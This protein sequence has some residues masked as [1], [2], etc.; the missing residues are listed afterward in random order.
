MFIGWSSKKLMF[1]FYD[2]QSS[3]GTRGPVSKRVLFFILLPTKLRKDIV[4]LPSFHS[5]FRKSCEHSRINILQWNLTK[6]GT[7]LVLKRIWNPID[8]QGQRSRSLGQ[9]FR[10]GDMPRFALPLFVS[11]CS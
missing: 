3:K 5:S 2:P 11:V 7:Y 1:Y 6:L 10:Q 4:T 8:F 9:F